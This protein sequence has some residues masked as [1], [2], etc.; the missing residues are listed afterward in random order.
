MGQVTGGLNNISRAVHTQSR[1]SERLNAQWRAFGT[2]IR[3]AFAGSVIF[4]AT[5]MIGLLRETQRQ[6]ALIGSLGG[7]A[8]NSQIQGITAADDA[9][10]GLYEQAQKGSIETLQPVREF[11]DALVNL[12]STVQDLSADKAIALTTAV[13]QGAQL[14][15]VPVD[16]L[17]RAVTGMNQAFGAEQNLQNVQKNIRGFV[18]LVSEAP[19][20]LAYGPQFIQQ[21]A[22]LSAVSRLAAISPE[23]MQG[24]FLTSLRTGGTPATAGRGLQYLLQS[25]AVPASKEAGVA[26][27]QAG[28]TPQAVQTKGGLWAL[29]RLMEKTEQLGITGDL[30]KAGKMSDESLDILE[31][32][33]DPK[34]AAL[35]LGVSGKGLTF[36][37]QAIGRIHGIRSIVALMAQERAQK[38]MSE[39][40]ETIAAAM[41]D[42]AQAQKMF[43]D[44][45]DDFARRQPLQAAAISVDVMQRQVMEAVEPGVNVAARGLTRAGRFAVEHPEGTQK[46]ILGVGGL[47][48]AA[49]LAKG[50]GVGGLIK[51]GG[52]GLVTGMAV[53]DLA[54]GAGQRGE[55]P[56]LPLYVT[57][58]GQIFGGGGSGGGGIPPVVGKTGG[59]G[60]SSTAGRIGRMLGKLGAPAAT[61]A[62][63]A[64]FGLGTA[65]IAATDAAIVGAILYDKELR[66]EVFEPFKE[67]IYGKGISKISGPVGSAFNK[68]TKHS[69]RFPFSAIGDLFQQDD[70]GG[71][72]KPLAVLKGEANVTV[73]VNLKSGDGTVTKKRVHV[74][75]DMWTGGK[76]PS[77][78]GKKGNTRRGGT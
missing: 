45:W 14:A 9:L 35:G 60:G 52:Q 2:T 33:A 56:N 65:A 55:T 74:P 77:S 46:V 70:K 13:S 49:G 7:T 48:A 18:S 40:Q 38:Q 1:L 71:K 39:D 32:S 44:K 3:Y 34:Q 4:G 72:G 54:R 68:A 53:R 27:N 50:M 66:N 8:F 51:R 12:Y 62:G 24:L 10:Q 42:T 23:Q 6:Y 47:M 73:D 76:V 5:R 17:T 22:P 11:N 31:Q 26:L 16:D 63:V 58:V 64:K 29:R 20:G 41:A 37:S 21:M 36:L 43:A 61:V 69:P 67:S 57:V 15:Q 78:R 75:V 25:I 19:G 30:S 59:G 28:I